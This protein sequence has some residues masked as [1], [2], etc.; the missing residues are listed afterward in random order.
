MLNL[1]KSKSLFNEG[2]KVLVYSEK[3]LEAEQIGWHRSGE[4]LAYY[5][6]NYRREMMTNY[7]RCYYTF[8]FTYKFEYD[9]DSV[10]FAYS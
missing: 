8:T 3:K 2:M 5:Q 10:F 1:Q 9:D 4:E 6:N 7:Q